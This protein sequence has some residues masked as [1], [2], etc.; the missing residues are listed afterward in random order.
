MVKSSS[1]NITIIGSGYVGMSLGT[2]L[3][4]LNKV[5]I[6]DID[7]EKV[8]KIN[9]G[10]SPIKDPMISDYLKN[11]DLNLKATDSLNGI[12]DSANLVI[13]ATPT[14]YND[15]TGRFDTSSVDNTVEEI[16]QHNNKAVVIIK[17]TIPEGHTDLLRAKYKTD[18]IIFSPE[19]LREGQ[20]LQDN[21]YPSRIIIGSKCANA[22]LFA[23]IL[24]EASLKKDVDI[25]FTSSK[26]AEAIKLFSNTSSN[27]L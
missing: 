23:N 3:S 12:I 15:E 10:I 11:Q 25:L 19:F 16:F 2:L 1:H 26:E 24:Q 4:Q 8:K 21:L 14:D 9:S 13:I 17:S 20:A 18:N 7:K 6:V 22:E 27:E 5:T